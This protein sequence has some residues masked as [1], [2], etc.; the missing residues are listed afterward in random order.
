MPPNLQ[1][2]GQKSAPNSI[3]GKSESF[4]SAKKAKCKQLI[5]ISE[6]LRDA[7]QH[8]RVLHLGNPGKDGNCASCGVTAST[9]AG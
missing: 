2:S 1:L 3:G 9:S 8:L 4:T 6:G 5:Y 7:T